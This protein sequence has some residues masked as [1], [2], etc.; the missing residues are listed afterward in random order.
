VLRHA[1]LLFVAGCLASDTKREQ[2]AN[3]SR[4]TDSSGAEFGWVCDAFGDCEIEAEPVAPEPPCGAE[5]TPGYGFVASRFVSIVGACNNTWFANW[6][7]PVVCTRDDD[8]PQILQFSTDYRFGC[9]RGLCQNVDERSFPSGY[10]LKEDAFLLCFG[11]ISREL[12]LAPGT[13]EEVMVSTW[14]NGACPG[15]VDEPCTSP[16]PDECL[17]P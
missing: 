5:Q 7:R 17:Q 2:V 6:T 16:L 9:V 3:P 4:L 1:L 12:T 10:V 11:P 15:F 8:C 13:P 14:V